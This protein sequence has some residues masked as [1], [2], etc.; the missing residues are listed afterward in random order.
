MTSVLRVCHLGKYYPP[1]PGGIETQVRTLA[2]AQAEMGADVRVFCVNHRG[3]DTVEEQDGLV[4]VTRFGRS[5][6]F[7]KLDLCPSLVS[8]LANIQTDILHLQVPNP[9]MILAI[10]KAR[11]TGQIV[12]TY[13]CD[14]VR[15]KILGRLFRPFERVA[16]RRVRA[17]L[18]TSPPYP[19]GSTF[20]KSYLDRLQVLPLGID[21]A[22]YLAPSCENLAEAERIRLRF[23]HP[24]W[25]TCGRLVYYKGLL[26]AIRA[27]RH[28]PGT[29]LLIGEG[30]ERP[31]L[32][33]EAIR[34]KVTDRVHFQ[35]Y[36]TQIIPYYLA[37]H[38]LWFP[39]NAR[40][41]AFGLVQVEAM[42]SGCPVINTAIPDSGVSWVSRHEE[43]GL[44]V[45][46]NDPEALA[47]A[48]VRLLNEP[49]LRRRLAETARARTMAEFD[50]RLMAQRSLSI[51]QRVLS[52][53][54]R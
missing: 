22:P 42:A 17:I 32:E 28:T 26:N 34:L 51:Y 18:A 53:G 27:M 24:I 43:T 11:P 4:S 3:R 23:P 35:K 20:L 10:L 5:A 14:L 19:E 48:A 29:L 47:A 36:I 6:S 37:A 39:S 8:A 44:T 30:P 33:R 16:Y 40:T 31:R 41:E 54:I 50:H 21:L 12:V 46:M 9:T 15:Q 38:A 13:N 1:A 7:A 52:E 25:I 49:G 45:A 2:R